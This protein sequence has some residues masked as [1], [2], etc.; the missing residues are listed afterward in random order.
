MQIG[1]L[2]AIYLVVSEALVAVVESRVSTFT[3][4]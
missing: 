4:C 2:S 1:V 3:L